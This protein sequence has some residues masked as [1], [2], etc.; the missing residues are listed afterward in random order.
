MQAF[1]NCN[2]YLGNM[3]SPS[4]NKNVRLTNAEKLQLCHLVEVHKPC[5]LQELSEWATGTF[6][7]PSLLPQTT[8]HDILHRL[9]KLAAMHETSHTKAACRP[10]G[11]AI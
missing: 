4:K 6:D 9:T 10:G 8:I 1:G 3:Q 5:T 7:L 2:G 11:G